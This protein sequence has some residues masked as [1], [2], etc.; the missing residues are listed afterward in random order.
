MI[1][2]WVGCA[3]VLFARPALVAVLARA[4][5]IAVRSSCTHTPVR[6]RVGPKARTSAVAASV[7]TTDCLGLPNHEQCCAE[8]QQAASLQAAPLPHSS[9]C[10]SSGERAAHPRQESR[11]TIVPDGHLPPRSI[12]CHSKLC[13]ALR[14]P[15]SSTPG[16]SYPLPLAAIGA[17]RI[18]SLI[19]LGLLG[20]YTQTPIY[21]QPI[22]LQPCCNSARWPACCAPFKSF[23]AARQSSCTSTGGAGLA[24]R[25]TS[26]AGFRCCGSGCGLATVL[27]RVLAPGCLHPLVSVSHLG[28]PIPS[29]PYLVVR[30]VA[31]RRH[32]V[33]V[34]LAPARRAPRGAAYKMI[35]TNV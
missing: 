21:V 35:Y 18:S 7:R 9:T 25:L 16:C 1:A 5:V 10:T 8:S 17:V 24:A 6:A 15:A 27:V 14:P 22:H 3:G 13:R 32:G 28:V 11:S 2:A 31:P 26:R 33:R 30:D 29:A 34:G 4:C 12:S 23:C 19:A 20:Q